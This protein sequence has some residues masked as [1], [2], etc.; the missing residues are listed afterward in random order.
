MNGIQLCASV[1]VLLEAI[2]VR[3]EDDVGRM[4]EVYARLHALLDGMKEEQKHHAEEVEELKKRL[5]GMVELH[6]EGE[7]ENSTD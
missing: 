4:H 1:I 5:S 2:S 7:H 6:V 3:G